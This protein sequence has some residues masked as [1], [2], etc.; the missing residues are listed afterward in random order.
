MARYCC[1]VNVYRQTSGGNKEAR[2]KLIE[3]NLRLVVYIARKFDNTGVELDDL[4]SVGTIGLIKA[5]NTFN[6][7]KN[8]KL[9]TYASR[10]I[11]NEIL[12]FLKVEPTM[13]LDEIS[14][15]IL[16]DVKKA[17]ENSG[18][19]LDKTMATVT[20]LPRFLLELV[21]FVVKRLEYH[22]RVPV[23]LMKGDPNYSTVLLSNLGS[24]GAK[25]C[26]HHL[27]NYGTCSLM[28]T[29]GTAHSIVQKD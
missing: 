4:I 11:D 1:K 17:R 29:I 28:F 7:D 6:P 2:N 26:Y 25:S 13:T 22:G 16:G 5:I 10:C 18:N 12:M 8:I 27:S 23:G 24:I 15:I 20:K 21:F 19:S 3:H 9:A 14:H